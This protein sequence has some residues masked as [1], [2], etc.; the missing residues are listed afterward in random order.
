MFRSEYCVWEK[1]IKVMG[2]S[3]LGRRRKQLP[4]DVNGKRRYWNLRRVLQFALSG[5]LALEDA[6]DL[7]HVMNGH[8]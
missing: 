3:I 6:V 7:D 5:E 8:V 2:K 1:E 4:N